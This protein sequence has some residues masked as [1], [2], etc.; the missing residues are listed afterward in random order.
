MRR[1]D[2]RIDARWASKRPLVDSRKPNLE[3]KKLR[4]DE[5][6]TPSKQRWHSL[7]PKERDILRRYAGCFKCRRLFAGHMQHECEDLPIHNDLITEEMGK[8]AKL[9]RDKKM[10][11]TKY[12]SAAN[13]SFSKVAT[14]DG[15][16]TGYVTD[17][18]DE[19][20][21]TKE[22]A[23]VTLPAGSFALEREQGDTEE[24]SDEDDS[25]SAD[26]PLSVPHLFWK[27]TTLGKDGLP[28]VVNTLLD[29]GAH[30]V[31]I[32]PSTAKRLGLKP[33]KLKKPVPIDVAIDGDNKQKASRVIFDLFVS[34]SLS[35]ADFFWTL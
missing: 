26:C 12:K 13:T 30:V 2:A 8:T 4:R 1:E 10:G 21:D 17:E 23:A 18:D 28:V 25:V 11:Q 27:A 6:G 20:E 22:V 16:G 33:K 9:A 14:L 5:G 34:L 3:F 35:S 15:E 32:R 29:C 19:K 7:S 24:D 31:L